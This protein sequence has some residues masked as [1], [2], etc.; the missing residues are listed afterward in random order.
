[1]NSINLWKNIFSSQKNQPEKDGLIITKTQRDKLLSENQ[2]LLKEKTKLQQLVKI[3]Q[4]ESE[5]KEEALYS[6]LLDIFDSLEFLIDYLDNNLQ[7]EN[8]NP[9]AFKRLPKFVGSM[10]EKLLT[11]LS[12]R[13]VEKIDFDED[14]PDFSVCKVVDRE[15]RDDIPEQTITKIVRQGF[16]IKEKI[17]RY[18]EVIT[19]K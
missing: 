15:I 16:K 14:T 10:Q 17:L 1:M 2:N 12:R 9:K 7:E 11:I 3:Q 8:F 6:E 19:A 13:E 4:Q 5:A 18:V